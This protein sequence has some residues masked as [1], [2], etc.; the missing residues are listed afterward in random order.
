MTNPFLAKLRWGADLT[1]AD[2]RLLEEITA[3]RHSMGADEVLISEGDSPD[4][5]HVIIEG[6][7]CRSKTLANGQRQITALLAPGDFSDLHVRGLWEMD[8]DIITLTPCTVVA[9]PRHIVTELTL[10]H[11]TIAQALG[12]ATLVD[13]A[14]LREWLAGVGRRPADQQ[15]AHLFCELFV[16]LRAVGLAE[17]NAYALPLTQEALSDVLGLSVVH[18]NRVVQRLRSSGLLEWRTGRVR[19]PDFERLSKFAGFNPNYLHLTRNARRP[20]SSRARG[21]ASGTRGKP[22]DVESQ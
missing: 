15:A 14:T 20:D 2:E 9:I 12:W 13:K 10:N 6:L 3:A 18:M 22:Q 17:D 4:Q 11:P 19:I 16:R 7:A 8:H 5:L 21:S 1:A